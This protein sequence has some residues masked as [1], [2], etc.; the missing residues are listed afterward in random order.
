VRPRLTTERFGRVPRTYVE[1]LRDRSV[2]PAVQRRMQALVPG[3]DR[4]AIDTGHAPQLA[5]PDRL[6]AL[7]LPVLAG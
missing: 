4:L 7:L 6:A 3:A 1:A 5:A 2:V